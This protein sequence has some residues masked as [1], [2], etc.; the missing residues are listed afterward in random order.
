MQTT[1]NFNDGGIG[2]TG[3]FARMVRES[4]NAR[5]IGFYIA[6]STYDI[7]NAIYRYLPYTE[8]EKARNAMAK[9]G[10]TIIPK[11]LNFEEFYL[12]RGGKNLEAQQA[13]FEEAKDLKKGQ[14]AKAFISA[15]NKRGTSRVILG[16]FIEKIA[17]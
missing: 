7:R 14:L 12:I 10:S 5:F 13:K 1:I 11:M 2:V 3:M 6:N 17:A 4:E 15:Q 9:N 16:R 8:Q